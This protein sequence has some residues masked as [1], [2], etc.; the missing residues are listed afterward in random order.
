MRSRPRSG[1]SA[2]GLAI[3][4]GGLVTPP[5]VAGDPAQLT[6][7]LD[8]DPLGLAAALGV[9]PEAFW[10]AAQARVEARGP[11]VAVDA[12]VAGDGAAR[13]EFTPAAP[14]P[15]TMRLIIDGAALGRALGGEPDIVTWLH[16]A[17][18]GAAVVRRVVSD[19][20]GWRLAVPLVRPGQGPGT[21]VLVV[22]APPG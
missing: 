1:P 11:G 4:D 15:V 19:P 18:A 5:L 22:I 13:M 16:A 21:P 10:N 17:G 7:Q 2:T 9:S 8:A 20:S 12:V 3:P 6:L 14:G